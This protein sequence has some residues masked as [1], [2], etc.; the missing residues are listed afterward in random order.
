MEDTNK[1]N[2]ILITILI[3]FSLFFISCEENNQVELKNGKTNLIEN[4][5][6][7]EYNGNYIWGG[8]MNLAW[9]ELNEEIIKD[10]IMLKTQNNSVIEIVNAFNNPIF[11]KNDIDKESYYI[12]SGYGQKI[13]D[14]INKESREKFPQKSFEDLEIKLNDKDIISYAYFFKKIKYETQFSK[15][16]V[17]F[18]NENVKGFFAENKKQKQNIRILNYTDENNFVI[19]IKLED[20]NDEIYLAKGFKQEELKNVL[21]IINSNVRKEE[22]REIDYFEMPEIHL[23]YEREYKEL[24]KKFLENEGFEDYFIAQMY[25]KIK[26]DMDNVGVRVENEAVISK[27]LGINPELSKELILN[28]PFFIVMKRKNS[29]NPYFI[30]YVKNTDFM[31]LIGKMWD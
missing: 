27:S 21:N 18:E 15:K 14:L 31:N 30:L 16:E 29:K 5:V 4:Y 28:K 24:I 20:E 22:M 3:F 8:A 1:N 7:S 9:S 17:N 19:D 23:N 25:E 2:F 11:T 26:F 10:K 12:K 13:V 6:G